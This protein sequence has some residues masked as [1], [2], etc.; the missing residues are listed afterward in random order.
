MNSWRH[1]CRASEPQSAKICYKHGAHRYKQ[2]SC[3][4]K[5]N[6]FR[7]DP[8][9]AQPEN[10]SNETTV[11]SLLSKIGPVQFDPRSSFS[12]PYDNDDENEIWLRLRAVLLRN[13]FER[14]PS[15]EAAL[16]C[17]AQYGFLELEQPFLAAKTN[18]ELDAK[19]FK[20]TGLYRRF[21]I[22]NRKHLS[23]W[24][25]DVVPINERQDARATSL[26]SES[27]K[28]GLSEWAYQRLIRSQG[29]R[30]IDNKRR[31]IKKVVGLIDELSR[32]M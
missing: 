18:D 20:I 22:N 27:P 4:I 19:E 10:R 23:E 1:R 16:A 30:L 26:L 3:T 29:M 13:V 32:T 28:L 25:K 24:Q 5:P 21:D 6:F 15:H 7:S 11:E 9:V 31:N 2:G 14:F 17:L 8:Y 12:G